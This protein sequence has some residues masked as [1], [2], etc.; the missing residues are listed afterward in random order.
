MIKWFSLAIA[1]FFIS[2]FSYTQFSY[3]HTRKVNHT[4]DYHGTIVADPYR[5]LENDTSDE[6]KQWVAAQNEVT[7]QYLRSITFRESIKSRLAA[8]Y[9]YERYSVPLENNGYYYFFKNDGLQNQSVLYRQKG[10]KGKIETLI[11]PNTLSPDAT[12]QLDIFEVSKDGHYAAYSISRAGSDWHTIFV[13]DLTTMK[14]LP[15]SVNWVKASEIQWQKNGF[16]YSRY[17][18]P[19]KGSEF[20]SA[21]EFHQVW[22]HGI[23]SSQ[24]DDRLVY[25]DTLNKQRFHNAYTS[26]D[27]R[28][29]FLIAQDRGKGLRGNSLL[30]HDNRWAGKTFQPIIPQIGNFDYHPIGEMGNHFYIVTNA[31][32]QNKKVMRFDPDAQPGSQWKT[33]VTEGNENLQSAALVGG[34]LF[35]RYLVDV[36]SRVYVYSPDGKKEREIILPGR[37]NAAGFE[38]NN[39]SRFTFYSFNTFNVPTHIY[40][41]DISTGKSELYRSPKIAFDA[42]QFET[43][44]EFYTSKDG[45]RV[46]VFIVMKKSLVT[47]GNNPTFLYGYGGFNISI[48]PFFS[49]SL[50][51]WLEQGGIFAVASIRGGAEYGE[52]WHEAGMFEKKQNVFDDF[53]AAAE[54][55]IRNKYTSPDKLAIR[56]GSNGGLLV[57]AVMNQRPD[58]FKVAI[59]EV[60]VM[61]MLRFQKFTIGWNWQAEYGSSDSAAAFKYLYAYSPLHNINRSSNYPATLVITSDHDDRVVPAHSFK[62]AATLQELYKGKNPVLIRIDTNSGHG[63]SNMMKSIE[64]T[65]DIYAFTLYNMGLGWKK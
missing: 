51:P 1:T 36:T 42:D 65:T 9:N 35:L 59:P 4:D 49:A 27:E 47:D 63:M 26:E 24:A 37:G 56:G 61:D 8:L 11:D 23:G 14:D 40:R 19:A 16:Y 50:I 64:L 7:Y 10:L 43:R 18:A 3:P 52:K 17:P 21:N 45:T 22:F 5:W 38:G 32:A 2:D 15:D 34:K 53:I 30:Y 6:T 31:D 29:V 25:S 46:P 39:S 60:G 20:S 28:Y 41:Y 58:L 55:L 54:Y 12:T 13:K 48:N 44:Q 57:G 33:I 62:Y